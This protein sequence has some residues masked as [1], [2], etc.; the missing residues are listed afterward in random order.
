MIRTAL[1]AGNGRLLRQ[2]LTE[3]FI[4]TILAAIAGLL[5]ASLSLELLRDFVS[6]I[7]PRAREIV[8]DR[9]V[10]VFATVN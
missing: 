9:G 7:T 10:L 6:Q 2:L 5:F 3:N 8:V 4:L 1:G